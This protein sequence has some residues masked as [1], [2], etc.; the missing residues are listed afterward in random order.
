[1]TSVVGAHAIVLDMWNMRPDHAVEIP[2]SLSF[3]TSIPLTEA[4]PDRKIWPTAPLFF[5]QSK[6]PFVQYPSTNNLSR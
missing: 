2:L 4:F 1:M 3:D 6:A 5:T